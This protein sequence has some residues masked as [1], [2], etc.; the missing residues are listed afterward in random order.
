MCALFN[1]PL[2][3]ECSLGFSSSFPLNLSHS[4]TSAHLTRIPLS[5]PLWGQT[6]CSVFCAAVEAHFEY[7]ST[8][9]KRAC[10]SLLLF[11]IDLP[12]VAR[13]LAQR[14]FLE[15]VCLCVCVDMPSLC[16]CRTRLP[17]FYFSPCLNL[18]RA[19]LCL[20]VPSERRE[21]NINVNVFLY[22][23]GWKSWFGLIFMHTNIYEIYEVR[24]T[25][26][27]RIICAP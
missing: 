18:F 3:F 9:N 13:H 12:P 24:Q 26:R 4:I 11:A 16:I 7:F 6:S 23:L 1:Y 22:C 14:N 8:V 19:L 2:T 20:N 21:V 10:L 27:W 15:C 25:T 17:V 5:T